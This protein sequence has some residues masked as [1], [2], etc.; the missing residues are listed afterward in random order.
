MICIVE[1][2]INICCKKVQRNLLL[3]P[4]LDI[5]FEV[6][7][8]IDDIYNVSA[9]GF[10]VVDSFYKGKYDDHVSNIECILGIDS[11]YLIKHFNQEALS[12]LV[13]DSFS[14]GQPGLPLLHFR[15]KLFS[16]SHGPL[17]SHH[18][19]DPDNRTSASF[20]RS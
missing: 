9:S 20:L 13:T 19:L 1:L 6:K 3:D 14:F 15:K 8:L 7:G 11:L 10:K 16:E 4:N 17:I 12:E 2:E 5:N 18:L